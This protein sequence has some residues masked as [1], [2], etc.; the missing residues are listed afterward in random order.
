MGGREGLQLPIVIGTTAAKEV[1]GGRSNSGKP[2][3]KA[4]PEKIEY[5]M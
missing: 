2:D 4:H 5:R 1:R 3:R